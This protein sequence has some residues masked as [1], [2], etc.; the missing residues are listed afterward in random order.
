MVNEIKLVHHIET[1]MLDA[2]GKAFVPGAFKSFLLLAETFFEN[3]PHLA[4][5]AFR[6]LKYPGCGFESWKR[7]VNLNGIPLE[8]SC[9]DAIDGANLPRTLTIVLDQ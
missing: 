1:Y 7:E 3:L 9:L 8:F 2:N 5:V 4:Y 6:Q